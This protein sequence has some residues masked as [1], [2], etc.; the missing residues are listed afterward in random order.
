MHNYSLIYSKGHWT[1]I[2][3]TDGS[4]I[5]FYNKPKIESLAL[6]VKQV[7]ASEGELKVYTGKGLIN[8]S[9][10]LPCNQLPKAPRGVRSYDR[11]PF[12]PATPGE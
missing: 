4:K 1:L 6:A 11:I 7:G 3:E 10:S 9:I 2:D 12:T 5:V 8:E